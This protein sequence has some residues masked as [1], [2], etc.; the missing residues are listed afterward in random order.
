MA[1]ASLITV[2]PL[3]V[4]GLIGR[5]V[6]KTNYISLCGL[7]AGSMTDPP[8]LAFRQYRGRLRRARH[9][10]RDRLSAHH[11]APRPLRAAA[12]SL[13]PLIQIHETHCHPRRQRGRRIRRLP[14][15][16]NDRDLS[17]HALFAHGRMVRRMV[18][19]TAAEPLVHG[20]ASRADAVR[21]RRG[22][23]SAWHAPDQLAHDDIHRVAGPA[24]H[25]SEPLQDRR[26]AA[27]LLPARHRAHHRP[28][29]RFRSSGITPT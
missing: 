22:G 25:D 5:I 14:A 3:L 1:L 19:Q 10:L 6:L 28:R 16:R 27:A 13:V 21:G 12:R 24:A 17:D 7:L 9:G 4:V 20:A 26:R 8:A 18:R 11:A 15:Q 2:V 23:S 29:T